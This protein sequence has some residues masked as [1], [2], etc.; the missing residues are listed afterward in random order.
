[1]YNF[2][3]YYSN[4]W[5]K[6]H[7][8]INISLGTDILY[9]DIAAL[10]KVAK[11]EKNSINKVMTENIFGLFKAISYAIDRKKIKPKVMPISEM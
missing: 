9:T 8:N 6:S 11:S 10:L 1:M 4:F 3:P 5:S 2:W 7:R